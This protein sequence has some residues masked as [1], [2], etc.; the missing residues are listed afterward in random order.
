MSLSK[1]KHERIHVLKERR[2]EKSGAVVYWMSRDQRAAD[3]WAMIYAQEIAFAREKPLAVVFCLVP[4]FLGATL[5]Q[6]SFMLKGLKETSA[7][8]A[9]KNIP[10]FILEGNPDTILPSF[11]SEHGVTTIVSDF[12][13][14]RTKRLWKEQ[15][16]K[17]T[18]ASLIEVDAH[19]IVP[20]RNASD[21]Q[22]WG[23]YTIR[24]KINRLLDE[25]LTGFP[26]LEKNPYKWNGKI[27][28]FNVEK[29]LRSVSADPSVPE[30]KD[31]APGSA[32]A[33]K[34][35]KNFL[36]TL[37]DYDRARNDPNENGQ[38]G[39]SPYLHFGQI[40][41]QKV[42]LEVKLSDASGRAK[43]AFLEELIVRRELADNF[44]LYNPYYDSVKGFP[45]WAGKTLNEH[46][47]DR[48]GYIYPLRALE[49]GSTHDDLWNAAQI[50]MVKTGKMH[51][52]MRMYWAKKILEWTS[53]PEQAMK[54][55]VYL[56]DRYEL[57]GRD[58]NGYAGIAWSIGGVHDRA[59]GERDIFGKIRYMSYK[60][61]SSKFD[62]GAYIKKVNARV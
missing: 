4:G 30:I 6:Y 22:E 57:D 3:N 21:K 36:K 27:P 9:A 13:P 7:N 41:A 14:L 37:N 39:L 8:L 34:Q 52:Y 58:P 24:P 16:M 33:D 45:D 46:R 31:I 29:L 11:A 49:T 2:T 50:Q 54:T 56:N 15:L 62:T 20:C 55:A 25:Y 53:T 1:V 17:R 10:L 43:E 59:W 5:R 32:A 35:L 47:K 40:S 38:S 28:A 42:A 12:D 60:G 44:C 26:R 19:N 18:P 61:C 48:R 51:G 23:A